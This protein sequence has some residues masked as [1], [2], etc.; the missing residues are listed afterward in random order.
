MVVLF[1][2]SSFYFSSLPLEHPCGREKGWGVSWAIRWLRH[3]T[4]EGLGSQG[5]ADVVAAAL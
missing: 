4:G 1:S 5:A 3:P 2:S